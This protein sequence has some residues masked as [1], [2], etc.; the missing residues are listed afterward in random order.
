MYLPFLMGVSASHYLDQRHHLHRYLGIPIY[1]YNFPLLLK[2]N[3][4][5][6][7]HFEFGYLQNHHH[8]YRTIDFLLKGMHQ[9][10]PQDVK[11]NFHQDLRNH[12]YQ[13]LGIRIYLD[14][15]TPKFQHK[16]LLENLNNYLHTR[17]YLNLD[18]VNFHRE[19]HRFEYLDLSLIHI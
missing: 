19:M 11:P 15:K 10:N 13:N 12:H 5:V 7:M 9:Q 1:L 18:T 6:A 14:R 17:H 2:D 16:N 8:Q 4:L 3:Y